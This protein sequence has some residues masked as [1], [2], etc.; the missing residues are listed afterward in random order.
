[1]SILRE[2]LFGAITAAAAAGIGGCGGAQTEAPRRLPDTLRVATLYS[3]TTYFIYRDE[4]MGYDYTLA[5]DFARAKGMVLDLRVARSMTE[6]VAMLDSGRVDLLACGVPVTS[7]MRG[8][9][10]PCGPELLTTQVLVQPKIKGE[11][12]ITDVTQLPGREVYVERGSK[13]E[14]RLRHLND[15]LGGGIDIRSVDSDSLIDEDLMQMVSDGRIPLTVVN[16]DVALLNATYYPDLDVSL[17]V[18]FPQRAAWGVAPQREWLADSIDAWMATADAR[19]DNADLLKRYFE[20]SKGRA[21]AVSFDFSKGYI[22]RFD[23]LFRTY[24]ERIG[25]DWRLLAA[26]GWAESRFRP[27]ARSWVGAR[28]L[29]QIMPRTARGYRTPVS[30]LNN[31]ETSIRVATRLLDDLDRQLK[32]YVPNDRERLKFVIGSYNVGIAHVLDAMRLSEKY[33]MNP[34][35]WDDNVAR[36][37]LMKSKPEYYNDPVV[38]YGYCRGSEPVG[39]V[40]QIMAFY[41]SAKRE[42]QA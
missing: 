22:S 17:E 36:A 24:A 30:Q 23:N 35:V 37:L 41:D 3:P 13:Y 21:S 19:R 14:Q 9:V 11:A 10:V 26:Q 34:Q 5:A 42:I 4:P 40:R 27:T 8:K 18:S 12:A 6:A 29:M 2:I 7:Q 15:E 16:R 32:P 20:M 39:Y 38:R 31:P 28:G 25:W 33:G 1:M